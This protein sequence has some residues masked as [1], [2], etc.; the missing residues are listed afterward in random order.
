[1]LKRASVALVVIDFQE[2]L[3][4]KIPVAEDT[5]AEA[6]RLIRFA[7]TLQLPI[8]WTEQYPKGLGPTIPQIVSELDGIE[9]LAKTAFGCMADSAF[10]AALQAT[11]KTNLLITGVETHVCVMQTAL[12][13]VERGFEVWVASDAVAAREEHQHKAG[14][15]RIEDSPCQLVTAEMAMFEILEK[16]GTP[17][18]KKCLPLLKG[19]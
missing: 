11:G 6:T 2:S 4:S 17:E 7:R 14:L 18:F 9:P 10:V 5:V 16:A 15:K 19:A 3:M 13:A 1:M 12:G 8:L